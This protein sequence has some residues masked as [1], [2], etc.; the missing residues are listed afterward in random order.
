MTDNLKKV[1]LDEPSN[2]KRLL[3]DCV[4]LIDREVAAKKG[5]SGLAIKGGFK[6]VQAVKPGFIEETM[7]FLLDE[8]VAHL[9]PVYEQYRGQQGENL[10]RFLVNRDRQVADQ[11]LG[12]T[13]KHAR[14]TGNPGVK[15]AYEKLRPQ[16]QNHVAEAIPRVAKMLTSYISD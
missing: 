14:K 2:R 13:D 16:A 6:I 11:L 4:N 7:D 9:E 12:I 8:F 1:L 15:K 5:L 3:G 10:E